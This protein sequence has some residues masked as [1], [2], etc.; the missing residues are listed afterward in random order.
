MHPD[1]VTDVIANIERLGGTIAYDALTELLT[2]NGEFTAS[3]IIARCLRTR[4]GALRW[5]LRFDTGLRPDIPVA[6]RMESENRQ[7]LDYYL[8]PHID[9]T[10]TK[11]RLAER[12][13]IF[14]DAY[15][16]NSLDHFFRL[17]GRTRLRIAA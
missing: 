16:F 4:A 14:F 9:I 2:I 13:G 1:V 7:P 5:N 6:L 17:A 11:V 8:L 15:R 10:A 3:I 12:N